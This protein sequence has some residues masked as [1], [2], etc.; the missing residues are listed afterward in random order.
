MND[1]D[2]GEMFPFYRRRF[3][4][5]EWGC[6]GAAKKQAGESFRVTTGGT[7]EIGCSPERC[8]EI[9]SENLC[10]AVGEAVT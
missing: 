1:A 7:I 8:S 6:Y 4:E 9:S 5:D 3:A 2:M 10:G